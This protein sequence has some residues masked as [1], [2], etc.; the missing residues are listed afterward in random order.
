MGAAHEEPPRR[1]QQ[2][3]PRRRRALL[4]TA[5]G[6]LASGV[7]H[8]VPPASQPSVFSAVPGIRA[9]AAAAAPPGSRSP[10]P[11]GS[12]SAAHPR[13]WR[14]RLSARE[15]WDRG[16]PTLARASRQADGRRG[17]RHPPSPGRSWARAA[18]LG[19]QRACGRAPATHVTVWSYR[20]AARAA[21][22]PGA[23]AGAPAGRALQWPENGRCPPRRRAQ[24]AW[25]PAAPLHEPY[26]FGTRVRDALSPADCL[27]RSWMRWPRASV[28]AGVR[29]AADVGSRL[30]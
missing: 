23:R 4:A 1:Q 15:R 25:E 20:A 16:G 24:T 14:R 6:A 21:K 12:R 10:P 30:G 3:R 5:A 22:P 2:S 7:S 17:H 18:P 13:Q 26:T 9:A 29:A 8:S 28:C 27:V 19:Q 11:P